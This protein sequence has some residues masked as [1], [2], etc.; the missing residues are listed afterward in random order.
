MVLK[1]IT[2]KEGIILI[3]RSRKEERTGF[4]EASAYHPSI[5]LIE[6]FTF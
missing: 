5:G 2:K 4:E 3:N 6:V 1:L